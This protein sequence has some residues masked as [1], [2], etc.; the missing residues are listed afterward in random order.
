M[1]KTKVTQEIRIRLDYHVATPESKP[2]DDIERTLAHL[3]SVEGVN[4]F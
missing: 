3:R 1:M 4:L 2:I